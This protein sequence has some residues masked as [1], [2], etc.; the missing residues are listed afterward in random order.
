ME[1]QETK[2][3]TNRLSQLLITGD[4]FIATIRLETEY[5]YVTIRVKIFSERLMTQTKHEDI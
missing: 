4:I 5:S 3:A 2:D 1:Q